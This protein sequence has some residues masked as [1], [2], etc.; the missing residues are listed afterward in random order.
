MSIGARIK[1]HR[2]ALRYTHETLGFLLKVDPSAISQWEHDKTQPSLAH[3]EALAAIL[4]CTT[5]YLLGGASGM[6]PTSHS[7]T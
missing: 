5:D 2:K 1:H 7:G 4:E 6:L 3:L